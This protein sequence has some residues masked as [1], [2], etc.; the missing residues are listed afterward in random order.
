MTP[1]IIFSD[2]PAANSGL[3]RITRDLALNLYTQMGDKFRVATLGYGAPGSVSLPFPQY[4]WNSN[5]E[6][7]PL[8]L[9]FIWRDFCG[10][11]PGVLLTIGDIQRFLPLADTNFCPDLPFGLWMKEKREQ[12]KLKLCGYFPID[13]HSIGGKLGPQL[14]H[15]LSHYDRILVPSEWAKTIV[16]KT[17]PG[18]EV[19]AIPHGIDTS[20]FYS[21]PKA[22]S[23]ARIGELLDS[24]LQW[25][26]EHID[27][28][29]DALWI[30]IVATNQARKDWG[31]GVEV[32]AEL[33]KSRP[34]FLWAHVDRLK[35][36]N[37]WSILELLSDFN[38]LQHSMVTVGNV[39]DETMAIAYSAM[40]ITLG[41][42][43]GEGFGYP[44]FESI[45]SGTPCF[46][47]GYGAHAEYMDHN[48]RLYP[49]SMRIEGPLNLLRPVGIAREW[50]I[51]ITENLYKETYYP[52]ELN[53]T[54]LWPRFAQWFTEGI[55]K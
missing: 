27:V 9:P 3:A 16:E 8:E 49:Q 6:F 40:D 42:G 50:A 33:R 21:R 25:P 34:V 35:S 17:L 43:R 20:T 52:K 28:G 7:L 19:V 45:F 22:E 41:I 1:I 10:S 5:F 46:A 37:G 2:H 23:R 11:D 44:I 47:Y 54:N 55:E 26:K 32:V 14:G 30:G 31:L 51:T 4:H 12:G 39:S 48:H 38:L 13:A 29:D 24:S 53:W 36:E 15:T 18:R